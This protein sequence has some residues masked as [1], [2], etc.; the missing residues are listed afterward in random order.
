MLP[1]FHSLLITLRSQTDNWGLALQ[2]GLSATVMD[3]RFCKPLDTAMIRALAKEHPVMLTVEEGSIGG[4]AA[5][6]MQVRAYVVAHS[7]H[8]HSGHTHSSKFKLIIPLPELQFLALEGLLD[9]DLKFRPMTLPDRYIEHGTQVNTCSLGSGCNQ[10]EHQPDFLFSPAGGAA[11]GG[12][13]DSISHSRHCPYGFG[14]QERRAVNVHSLTQGYKAALGRCR[15]AGDYFTVSCLYGILVR[16]PNCQMR[17][18]GERL[19]HRPDY[20]RSPQKSFLFLQPPE[21]AAQPS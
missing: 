19:L 11:G 9:G 12:W 17:R 8:T 4:F 21:G 14:Y 20:V 2:A 7:G 3:A 5:H 6:V 13:L 18:K 10:Q 16:F 15:T 1:A